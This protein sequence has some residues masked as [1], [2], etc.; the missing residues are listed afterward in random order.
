MCIANN[1]ISP[2]ISRQFKL[3]ITCKN[4]VYWLLCR[5]NLIYEYFLHFLSFPSP[6]IFDIF[7]LIQD[8]PKVDLEVNLGKIQTPTPNYEGSYS[9]PVFIIK[10]LIDASPLESYEISIE[11]MFLKLN[12]NLIT[13]KIIEL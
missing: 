11:G 1:S 9:N 6:W 2:T 10:C 12:W 5:L 3:V 7:S 13:L 8:K 4:I